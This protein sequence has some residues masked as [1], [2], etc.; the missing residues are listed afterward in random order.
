MTT[1]DL[2]VI[3]PCYNEQD[4]LG[5]LT[6]RCLR[7]FGDRGLR[8]EVVLVDD[9][10]TDGTAAKIHDLAQ[11]HGGEVHGVFHPVN[12]GIAAAW[13]SGVEAATGRYTAVMDAD[14]Q[15]Q[16]ED[17]WRLYRELQHTNADVVQGY[18]S[19]IGRRKHLRYYLSVGLN[20]LLNVMFGMHL[21]DNKS[22]FLICE[23]DVLAHILHHRFRYAYFQT[24]IAV[25]AK[26]KGYTVREIETLF[27][28]RRQGTSFITAFPWRVVLRSLADLAKG[29]V[30][31]RL[32]DLGD[33]VLTAFLRSNPPRR[34]PERLPVGRA[35]YF[36]L[37][38]ALMPVHHWMISYPALRYYAQLRRTQW[39]SA[40][41][42]EAYQSQKLQQLV[43]H[44]YKHVPFYRERWDAA[45][46]RPE[47][48]HSPADLE[49]LPTVTKDD[50]R[51]NLHF[52]LLADTHDKGRILKITTSGSTGE[53]L[54][55]YADKF[56]L[57][58]RWATTLRTL[59]WTGY[60]FGDRCMRLWHTT[61]GMTGLQ[62][63]RER[64]DAWFHRRTFLS[65]YDMTEGNLEEYFQEI[66]R[67]QPG[68]LDG[69]AESFNMLAAYLKDHPHPNVRPKG[70]VSSAQ[71]LSDQSRE[72][73]EAAF[74]CSV[75]DKYGSREFSGIAHECDAHAGLHVNAES[76][77]VEVLKDGR[78]AKPGEVGEVCITDLNNLCVP[79]IR[80]RLGDLA[81]PAEAAV[82]PCGRSLPRLE[83]V[84][85]R[86]QAIIMGTNGALVP[87]T[88]FAHLLKDYDYAVR[89]FQVVQEERGR[90]Q[91][92]IIKGQRYA[93]QT[94][95]E[96]LDTLHARLGADMHIDVEFV[97]EIAL[98][99]TGKHYHSVSRLDFDFQAMPGHVGVD[100][101]AA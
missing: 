63:F 99:R 38:G 75:F 65:A 64:L 61:I 42:L 98:G 32:M 97:E 6:A 23:R 94:L 41:Q 37:F 40:E 86:V 14:L 45:G 11:A 76:Y 85:G 29:I 77:I 101:D 51:E 54:V 17:L 73:I 56:Q 26:H 18:R 25:S 91:L 15:Y 5:E 74:Q 39:W 58:M 57:E 7:V 34:E 30:E 22:G 2:S 8:G 50:V 72:I 9:G 71:T 21:R 68:L 28:D 20:R 80:Y 66:E 100:V 59:E 44:A 79:L 31:F 4:N 87:G 35:L 78:P 60:R 46:V 43:R 12:R 96:I 83:R 55:L 13:R 53:P 36:R 62:A 93:D 16:P 24:F 3:V 49:R 33:D 88:Y 10:S 84:E 90:I 95:Q 19:Q 47:F 67:R 27:E 52:D 92:K 89:Q 48:V 81:V 69:Y 70:I 1:P 82:C